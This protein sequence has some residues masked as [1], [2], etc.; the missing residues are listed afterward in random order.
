MTLDTSPQQNPIT[1]AV[2][3]GDDREEL[4]TMWSPLGRATAAGGMAAVLTFTVLGTAQQTAA[5]APGTPDRT[6]ATPTAGQ[7]VTLITG[8]VVTVSDAGAGRHTAAVRPAPGRERVTF[9]TLEVDGGLRV[10]PSDVV[11]YVSSGAVDADLF[12]VEEL[13]AAGYGDATATGLPLIVRYADGG[14]NARRTA[15]VTS[16]RELPSIGGSRE[17]ARH[18]AAGRAV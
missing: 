16:V 13:L 4:D 3:S 9:H 5:A 12:D 8:D 15:G 2:D 6:A 7:T 18:R 10:L 14:A 1:F 11:P 17:A